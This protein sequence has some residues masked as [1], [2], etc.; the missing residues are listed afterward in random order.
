MTKPSILAKIE[1]DGWWLAAVVEAG[2]YFEPPGQA[3]CLGEYEHS[4]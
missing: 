2:Q 3:E 4:I 1:L